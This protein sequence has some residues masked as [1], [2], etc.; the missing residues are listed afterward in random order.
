[1]DPVAAAL[2]PVARRCD[3]LRAGFR[4]SD[5][6]RAMVKRA[7]FRVRHGW[8]ARRGTPEVVVRAVRVGGV[9]SGLEAL[10]LRGLFVPRP[11]RIDLVVPRHASGLRSP[12]QM[13]R[14]L[15][16]D[17]GYRIHWLAENRSR[18]R[19]GQ[20]LASEDDALVLVLHTADREVAVAACDALVRYRGWSGSRLDAAFRRAPRRVQGWRALVDGRA[21]SW[22]ETVARLRVRDAGL[23][24]EPQFPVPGAGRFDGRISSG[25]F[26]EVDGAQHADDWDGEGGSSFERD[27]DKDLA[28][29]LWGGRSIRI[30]YRQ[31][32][33][34][35]DA[36]LEAIRVAVAL[37][38]R[39]RGAAATRLHVRSR[40]L[41][42]VARDTRARRVTRRPRVDP[43]QFS[44]GTRGS[45]PQPAARA[46]NVRR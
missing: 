18:L 45:A 32:E 9:V 22:G 11:A 10:H 12:A 7:I 27:H 23:A 28:L 6:R 24:F 17:A 14:R 31:L 13:R 39:A 1:M 25:V 44:A 42:R 30:T 21:D 34:D 3:L 33:H 36:C 19:S 35:W 16:A 2:H 38:V 26:L 8:Y 15:P 29:A 5:I 4:D 20:W 46:P 40:K 41:R 37:D 43:P